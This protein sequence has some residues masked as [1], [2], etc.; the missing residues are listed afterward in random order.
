MCIYFNDPSDECIEE[1]TDL[2][3]FWFSDTVAIATEDEDLED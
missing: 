2:F 3:N 1:L